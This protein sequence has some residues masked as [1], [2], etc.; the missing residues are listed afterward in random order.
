M[1]LNCVSQFSGIDQTDMAGDSKADASDHV[2][3][4]RIHEV[5]R[6]HREISTYIIA[7]SD[8]DFLEAIR[9]LQK[10]SKR[11]ILWSLRHSI[12]PSYKYVM[13]GPEAITLE[14][15]EDIVFED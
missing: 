1:R 15:L 8:A 4:E 12:N 2:L 14:W 13:S 7:T 6:E 11:V 9:T 10:E 3:R 5:L